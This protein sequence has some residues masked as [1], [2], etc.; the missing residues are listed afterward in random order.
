[1]DNE[2]IKKIFGTQKEMAKKLKIKQQS[3]SDWVT[4]KKKPSVKNAIQIER[5]SG[6]LVTRAEI[7]PDI[8]GDAA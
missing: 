8:F 1:M 4:G 7:R 3:V 6:G 5:L 2:L